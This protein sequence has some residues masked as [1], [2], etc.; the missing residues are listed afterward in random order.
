[1]TFNMDVRIS[2]LVLLLLNSL[3]AQGDK[4][5]VP[6]NY[7]S[8]SVVC[9]CDAHYCDL[10]GPVTLPDPGHYTVVTSS[11]EGHRF[12]TETHELQ[13]SPDQG[14]A[15][16]RVLVEEPGQTML[17]FGGAFTDSAGINIA[18]LSAP[19]QDLL[20]RSYFGPDGVE[21][22]LCRVPIAGTDFSVRPYSYADLV[23]DDLLLES[24]ALADEDKLYKLPLIQRAQELSER[25][26]RIFASPWA[27]PAW[28]KTNRKLNE[29][30]ELL[31]EMWQP[32]SNYLLKFVK[33]YE[34]EG[35]KLWGLT[36]Q[37]HA[38]G[39]EPIKWNSL[40]W[41][42]ENMRDWIK[43]SLGPTL[44]AA[45]LGRL[46]VMVGDENRDALLWYVP[47]CQD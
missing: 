36:T 13:D 38:G 39:E 26:L 42:S 34:A 41:K 2:L 3:Q 6:R 25:S 5:C 28:M 17:G 16:L 22:D 40:Y 18:T 37:N 29:S 8:D 30:G 44:E 21:Y 32:W 20:M 47:E 10:P 14:S 24:F 46:K 27:P 1:M 7:G 19:A 43:E 12:L 9:V 33:T 4:N 45:G 35:V 15:L 11:R 23:E 31:P